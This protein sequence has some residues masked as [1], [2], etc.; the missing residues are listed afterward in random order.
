MG[1]R[2]SSQS[3]TPHRHQSQIERPASV[4]SLEN[5]SSQ[6]Y[7][8]SSGLRFLLRSDNLLSDQST[9][10]R[11]RRD[12]ND[13][14][15]ETHSLP[16]HLFPALLS[17]EIKCPVCNRRI[18]SDEVEAHLQA[19]LAK[20]KVSYN[21]DTLKVD[22]GE[23]IIC[24]DDMNI[25]DRIARLPC[26]CI[27]HK[28]C[29]DDWFKRNRCCPEHPEEI[30]QET[31]SMT[32]I[33]DQSINIACSNFEIENTQNSPESQN[34]TAEKTVDS[35]IAI[36]DTSTNLDIVSEVPYNPGNSPNFVN[37]CSEME[38]LPNLENN[39][40]MN[41]KTDSLNHGLNELESPSQLTNKVSST[42]H[43]TLVHVDEGSVHGSTALFE[44]NELEQIAS[45]MKTI[46]VYDLETDNNENT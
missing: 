44:D 21:V 26:L 7:V 25:G 38:N 5:S 40:D 36:A 17:A 24:F 45:K 23:C 33:Q 1:G 2:Q 12:Q 28:K 29:I 11:R 3:T 14:V 4:S 16:V 9:S 19:C 10:R 39:L 18:G 13:F 6:A 20:P 34:I 43:K 35:S 32:N 41:E 15:R 42:F 8:G 46:I 37:A 30:P 22:A 31:P 27:Y